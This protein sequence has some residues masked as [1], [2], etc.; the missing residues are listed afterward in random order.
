M[1]SA[2]RDKPARDFKRPDSLVDVEICETSGLL[3][4]DECPRIRTEVFI[5]GTEP[6]D[7]DKSYQLVTLDSATGLLWV[8]GC[9]GQPVKRV[10]RYFPPEAR[11]WADRQGFAAPPQLTCLGSPPGAGA[12]ANSASKDATGVVKITSPA[13]NSTFQMS[14]QLPAEM[15][16]IEIS[17]LVSLGERPAQVILL[18]DGHAA[19]TWESAPYRLLWPISAGAHTV[20][21]AAILNSGQRVESEPVHFTVTA[22]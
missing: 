14:P 12:Q 15:Q 1:E 8:D 6:H 4:G 2:L 13:A 20:Q 7:T 9:K 22:P 17:A 11:D 3:P 21:A 16:Q 10:V 5:T 18:I 19:S